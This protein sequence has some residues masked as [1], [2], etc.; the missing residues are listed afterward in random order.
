MGDRDTRSN[1][2][3]WCALSRDGERQEIWLNGAGSVGLG[4]LKVQQKTE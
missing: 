1:K 3:G 4:M 2:W